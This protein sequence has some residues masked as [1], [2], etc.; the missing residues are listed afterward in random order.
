VR[1]MVESIVTNPLLLSGLSGLAIGLAGIP[2]PAYLDRSLEILGDSAVPIALLCIGGSLSVARLTGHRSR[3]VAAAVLKVA[4]APAVV[5]VLASLARLNPV[6]QRIALIFA[7]SPTAAAAYV[8][9]RQ[10]GGDAALASGSIALSTI[11]SA[12]SL[13]AALWLTPL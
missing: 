11:L 3:I 9:A 5:M 12:F 8:M 10:M 13:A 2:L 1:T 7:A 4:V 6:E